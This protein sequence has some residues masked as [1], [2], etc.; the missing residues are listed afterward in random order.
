M[1]YFSASNEI[2]S[3]FVF[4]RNFA[5]YC[6]VLKMY[7]A[8][9]YVIFVLIVATKTYFLAATRYTKIQFVSK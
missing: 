1:I 4:I 7:V 2:T 9:L 6:S 5:V 8:W 3:V